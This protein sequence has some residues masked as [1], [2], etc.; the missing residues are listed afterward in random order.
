MARN[1]KMSTHGDR[2]WLDKK[3]GW[4]LWKL[5]GREGPR[6]LFKAPKAFRHYGSR[7][8][9]HTVEVQFKNVEKR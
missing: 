6:F 4:E 2:V 5:K 9:P 8:S 7:V 1:V 3:E